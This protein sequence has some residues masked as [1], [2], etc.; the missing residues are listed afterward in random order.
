MPKLSDVR[1][2]K[3]LIDQ[4]YLIASSNPVPKGGM[5]SLRENLDAARALVRFLL[6]RPKPE[7]AAAELGKRG[8]KKTAE[9]GPEYFS[10]I[11]SMRKTKAGGRPRKYQDVLTSGASPLSVRSRSAFVIAKRAKE[12]GMDVADV[13]KAIHSSFQYTS[14]L[15]AGKAIPSDG[16]IQD[17]ISGLNLDDLKVDQIK[18]FAAEDRRR[19]DGRY[20]REV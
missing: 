9:R 16:K 4:A 2:L 14:N 8:G 5:E 3:N 6:M 15:L 18:T 11:A 7:T 12:L 20:R 1:T 10:Q 19:N 13:A 17:I